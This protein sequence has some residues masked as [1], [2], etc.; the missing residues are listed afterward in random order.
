MQDRSS[1]NADPG[2]SR[3]TT[4]TVFIIV[5]HNWALPFE[6]LLHRYFGSRYIGPWLLIAGIWPALFAM[7]LAREADPGWGLLAFWP[8]LCMGVA[9]WL[10]AFRFDRLGPQRHTQY[11]GYPYLSYL[12]IPE[13]TCKRIV[14]PCICL[15]IGFWLQSLNYSAGLFVLM[16]GVALSIKHGMIEHYRHQQTADIQ[17]A[18]IEQRDLAARLPRGL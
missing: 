9:H 16:G 13:R 7:L 18:V 11:D 14:E 8:I 2:M 15:A 6:L 5:L 12:R 4:E 17:D 10:A 3:E 1:Q